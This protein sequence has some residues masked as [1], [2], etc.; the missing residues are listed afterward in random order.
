MTTIVNSPAPA[1]DSGGSS[2]LIG[3]IILIV[4]VMI[5]LYFGI[6]AIQ[7]MGPIQVSVPAP[8]V[9]IPNKVDVNVQPAK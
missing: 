9:N 5:L 2:F 6:P 4:F 7:R 8:V 3:A 1:A